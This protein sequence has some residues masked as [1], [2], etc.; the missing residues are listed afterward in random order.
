MIRAWMKSG[1][2]NLLS[3]SGFDRFLR[4]RALPI[5][6][7]YHRVIEDFTRAATTSIPSM[8]VSVKMLERH[9]DWIGRRY[10]FADL[11][12]LGARMESGTADRFAAVTFDDGYRDFY[13]H[14]L[15][16]LRRKGIPAAV[17]VV[18]QHVGTKL[19]PAHDRLYFLLARRERMPD[20]PIG[21]INISGMTPYNAMRTMVESLPLG[22]L[23]DA[24]SQLKAEGPIP[25]EALE[26]FASLTWEDL[27]RIQSEGHTIGSHTRTHALLTRES[28]ERVDREARLSREEIEAKLG[29]A[30]RH[31]AYPGGRFDRV[32][33][34]AV[35]RAGYHFAYTTCRHRSEEYRAL[36]IPRTLLWERS[37]LNALGAFSG[38]VLDCQIHHAFDAVGCREQHALSREAC[39]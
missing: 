25:D 39:Q 7:G 9:L 24:I 35:A 26:P 11:D 23:E 8:L 1:A 29:F 12:E 34:D 21:G 19:V 4:P 2:A 15:P 37:S 30:V 17:F 22:A 36:T 10:R 13:E 28:F 27:A 32:A 5:V 18:T 14:A 6:V 16:L 20:R 38:A 33:V 31:F 3:R